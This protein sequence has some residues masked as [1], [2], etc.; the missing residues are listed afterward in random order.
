MNTLSMLLRRLRYLLFRDQATAELEEEMRFHRDLRSESL[1]LQGQPETAARREASR[2]FGNLLR[3]V[4]QSRDAW[5]W[6]GIDAF[7]QDVRYATRRL[8]QRPGFTFSVVAILT[9][10]IGATTAMFSAVDA[11]FLR[12]LPFPRPGELLTLTNVNI[13]TAL[14]GGRSGPEIRSFDIDHVRDMDAV[15]SHVA[16]YASG[17]LNLADAERP[18]RV[19]AG[20]VSGDFFATLSVRAARG[21]TLSSIDAGRDVP[22]VVVL[23]WNLWQREFGAGDVIG[24]TIP[25]NTRRYEIVGVMPSGFTFPAASDL[26]IPMSI[27]TTA[28]TFE[29]FRGYLPTTVIARTAP[30]V[31]PAFAESQ[32]RE[33][34]ER[35][36]SNLPREPGRELSADET[37]EEVLSEGAS[38]PLR[39]ALVSE[40]RTALLVLFVAT[41]LLLLIACANVTS[42]LLSYGMSRGRELAVRTVLGA[43]RGRILRQLLAESVMLSVC[44]AVIGIALAPA[45]LTILRT[46]MPAQLLEVAPVRLDIRVLAFATILALVTGILFGLWPALG[47]TRASLTGAIRSGSGHGSTARGARRVQRVL[48]AAE[49]AVAGLLLTGA[50]LMLRSF[51]RLLAADM[52]MAADQVATLEMSFMRGTPRATRLE[53]LD[54]ILSEVRRLPT[55]SAAGAVNDLPLRGKG[56][57]GISVHVDGAP[58]AARETFPRYLVASDGYFEA[59]GIPLRKGRY[60]ES[61]DGTGASSVAVINEAMARAFW[62]GANPIGQTFLFGGEPPPVQVVGVV[63]DVREAGLEKDPGPQM[64]FPARQNLDVNLAL[65]VRGK[66]P[67]KALLALI[68]QAVRSVDPAQPVY[69]VRMMGDVIG[70]SMSSRRANTLLISLFGILALLIAALGVYAVTANAVAQRSREFGIR[71]ALGATRGELFRQ[72]SREAAF[73]IVVGVAGG[74]ALA[75]AA[76]RVMTGLVYEVSVYDLGTFVTTPVVL[77]ASAMAATILP[78]RRAMR[79]EPV[80]VMRDE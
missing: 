11:A 79:V 28:A 68:T 2:R 29:P 46:V 63:A 41:V 51:E 23:S 8:R 66:A 38:R 49:I 3:S 24:R 18:R 75:W 78:A 73:V 58:R 15:F 37:L 47:A 44:G 40:R 54:A 56:G 48:V 27:P 55:V 6:G 14:D 61:T 32:L 67:T 70:A 64:Y 17:G 36:V 76:A 33:A 60:F 12:P 13:P 45:L 43:S 22:G 72:V 71:A 62:P 30:G 69:N 25:L 39:A 80:E 9:L 26:W 50:G 4:E 77:I 74:G 16:S 21:R 7:R 31:T 5:G 19:N 59:L 35:V 53:R 42:L 52:G 10:G 57:I 20:V 34:W 1:Q 65:V